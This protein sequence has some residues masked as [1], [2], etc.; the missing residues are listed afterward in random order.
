VLRVD[1]GERKIGLSRRQLHESRG[2]TR[3][4]ETPAP[5][6]TRAEPAGL[7]GGLGSGPLFSLGGG[8]DPDPSKTDGILG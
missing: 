2:D 6:A 7:K 4:A 3:D 5:M 1:Q 8:P